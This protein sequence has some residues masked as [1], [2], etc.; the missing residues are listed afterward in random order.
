MLNGDIFGYEERIDSELHGD[1]VLV[2]KYQTR[3]AVDAAVPPGQAVELEFFVA[4]LPFRFSTV[5]LPDGIS[6]T[7]RRTGTSARGTARRV[8]T[9]A[10]T[11]AVTGATRS[12]AA[13]AT[14]GSPAT[15]AAPATTMARIRPRL[16]MGLGIDGGLVFDPN[17]DVFPPPPPMDHVMPFEFTLTP[18][19]GLEPIVLTTRSSTRPI[20]S[21][22][23]ASAA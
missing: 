17:P 3:S 23:R 6:T 19:N 5:A 20:P 2:K 4:E 14:P 16:G 15:P 13:V 8:T 18:P 11:R 10:A 22:R 9:S 1:R 21:R 7:E 12:T